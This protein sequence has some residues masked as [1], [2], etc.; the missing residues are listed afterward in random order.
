MQ[1]K[2]QNKDPEKEWR[3]LYIRINGNSEDLFRIG[4]ILSL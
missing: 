4:S 2:I 3:K 1:M